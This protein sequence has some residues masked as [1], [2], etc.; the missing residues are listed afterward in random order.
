MLNNDLKREAIERLKVAQKNYH[1][2][3]DRVTKLAEELY[4]LRKMSVT[5]IDLALHYLKSLKA[6]P[7]DLYANLA[8]IQVDIAK[9]K[10]FIAIEKEAIVDAEALEKDGF[11]DSLK[12][13]AVSASGLV[14]GTAT[15]L[16]GA[17]AAVAIA[18][19]FGTAS[20]GTAIA[21]LSGAAASNA[22]LAWLGGGALAAGGG[23]IAAGEAL[24]A[25]AGPVGLGIAALGVAAGSFFTA[26]KNKKRAE[27]ANK[28]AE[29]LEQV[30]AMLDGKSA[31]V[32]LLIDRT[33]ELLPSLSIDA[34]YPDSYESA[35]EDQIRKVKALIENLY[36][37]VA[38]VNRNIA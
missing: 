35:S 7:L 8:A 29:E 11:K 3:A 2:T 12:G 31:E 24:L 15:A 18:T 19:T 27:D 17:S 28:A 4:E 21:T 38:L 30:I 20:T 22:A 32:R 25:L 6:L 26:S 1:K 23:G 10:E 16:G 9:F 5:A 37:M 14:A 33:Q 34:S 36:Q 13:A